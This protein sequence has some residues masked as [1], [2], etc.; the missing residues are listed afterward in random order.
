MSDQQARR[1]V[2]LWRFRREAVLGQLYNEL[3][4]CRCIVKGGAGARTVSRY[5]GPTGD[6]YW[7]RDRRG[8]P[9]QWRQW[10]QELREYSMTR[11]GVLLARIER[12]E[13]MQP[14]KG[15]QTAATVL[16]Q[17]LVDAMTL[18]GSWEDGV[19]SSEG[20]GGEVAKV[21]QAFEDAQAW[22]KMFGER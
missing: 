4:E 15:S 12:V 1:A 7:R 6:L 17:R 18:W 21:G 5:L 14:P 2:K 13:S 10:K 20:N 9:E 3:H 19:P 8:T 22:L 16:V 11:I